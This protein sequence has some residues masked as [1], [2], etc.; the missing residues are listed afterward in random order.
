MICGETIDSVKLYRLL[1][2]VI[3]CP[4]Y[5]LVCVISHFALCK[6][7]SMP[8][9][10][11]VSRLLRCGAAALIV[12]AV[13]MLCASTA[14]LYLW[15]VSDKNVSVDRG[16]CRLYCKFP[17]NN[18]HLKRMHGGFRMLLVRNGTTVY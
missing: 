13:L 5:C 6:E 1:E 15:K 14:A 10:A 7:Q 16:S 18:R 12:G 9:S 17:F 2:D 3:T 11:A 8:T 4:G